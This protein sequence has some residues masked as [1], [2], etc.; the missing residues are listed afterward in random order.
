M[1]T[2]IGKFAIIG[3]FFKIWELWTPISSRSFFELP[4][5]LP[6]LEKGLSFTR[7]HCR[8]KI[9]VWDQFSRSWWQVDTFKLT[10]LL[11]RLEHACSSQVHEHREMPF[12]HIFSLLLNFWIWTFCNVKS[13]D[14]SPLSV[15]KIQLKKM[16]N[17]AV[18]LLAKQKIERYIRNTV[19]FARQLLVLGGPF[20]IPL[21][22]VGATAA[23]SLKGGE[24]KDNKPSYYWTFPLARP[25]CDQKV[26]PL[27]AP[28]YR[29]LAKRLIIIMI[30]LMSFVTFCNN[31]EML[32]MTFSEVSKRV[33]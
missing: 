30:R 32:K 19:I 16:C 31:G 27:P 22:E 23:W 8:C 26:F 25:K 12:W 4:V 20:G 11:P 15:P 3:A 9:V 28:A 18:N 21:T 33:R 14:K 6:K 13:G 17:K 24:K 10:L 5:N 29:V 2:E 1:R 7:S